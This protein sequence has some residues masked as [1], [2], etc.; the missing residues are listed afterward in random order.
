MR[1][2][3]LMTTDVISINDE[4][5][6]ADAA[7]VLADTHVSGIAVLDRHH[8]LVGA[9]ST[10]DILAVQA[11]MENDEARAL[12]MRETLVRDAMSDHPLSIGPEA[13]IREA[14]LEMEYADVHRLFVVM[15]GKLVGVIS[16]SDV[17]RGH[18]LGKL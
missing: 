7:G 2:T 18:A 14:A 8:R 4:A 6:L 16:R 1:V 12:A 10:T 5:T 3:E 17:S 13:S 9:I 15:D 11:E